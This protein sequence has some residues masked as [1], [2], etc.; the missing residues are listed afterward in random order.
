MENAIKEFIEQSIPELNG[1]LYP[2]FTTDLENLTIAYKFTPVSGGHLKQSQLELKIIDGDY[3]ACKEMEERVLG[4]LDMENDMP[5][6]VTGGIRFHSE[7][8]GG[9][10]LYNDGCQMWEDT[11]YFIVDW[12]KVNVI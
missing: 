5:F 7:L 4:L 12:R 10:I 1:R 11:L 8:G 2:V 6:V 3:D 9:G